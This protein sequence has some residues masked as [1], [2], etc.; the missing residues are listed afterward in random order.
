M[1]RTFS[2]SIF[3]AILLITAE[4][5]AAPNYKPSHPPQFVQKWPE[6]FNHKKHL[7]KFKQMG[8]SC[9]E[10]HTFSVKAN[11][12]D[13]LLPGVSKGYLIPDKKICHDCHLG[14]INI[15]R[16][17]ECVLC[18]TNTHDLMPESHKLN[19][20]S[21]HGT[22]AEMDRD[23]CRECHSDKNC[24]QCH[25]QRDTS[26]PQ[27]HRPNF[28]ISHSIEARMNPQKCVT[29]HTTVNSCVMCHTRGIK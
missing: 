19:W 6:L 2:K 29:C 28:R 5:V 12:S 10:C 1:L 26:K 21:R 7:E 23:S 14:K 11:T 8:V 15:P 24:T 16:S 17:N 27:V 4:T 25:V 9:T 18:H 3:S 13:P 20:K 22:F